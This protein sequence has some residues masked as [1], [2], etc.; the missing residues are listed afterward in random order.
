LSVQATLDAEAAGT[1]VAPRHRHVRY[2][3]HQITQPK[4]AMNMSPRPATLFAAACLLAAAPTLT[5]AQSIPA[6]TSVPAPTTGTAHLIEWDLTSLPDQLDGNPGAMVVDSRGEDQNR[7]WFIT[8]IGDPAG[9]PGTAPQ[10]V[11]RFDPARSLYS[12]VARWSSW[13]LR[14]DLIAGGIKK[15]KPSH[16]R[17][18]VFA[19]TATF[20]QK[21]DTQRCTAGSGS[22]CDRTVFSYPD[23]LVPEQNP[24]VSVSDIAVDDRNKVF[25]TGISP[26]FLAGY[27]QMLN[28]AAMPT[29][30]TS[31]CDPNT[32]VCKQ[33]ITATRWEVALGEGICVGTGPSLVCNAGI[34]V[35]PSKQNLVYFTEPGSNNIVELNI[36]NSNPTLPNNPNIRRWDVTLLDSSI[37]QPR[38]LKIDRWGRVWVN[39]G[40]GHL[41]SLDPSTSKMTKHLLPDNVSNDLFGIAPDDD[42]IGYTAPG[43]NKVGMLFPKFTP[44]YVPFTKDAVPPKPFEV[45]VETEQS[46][47]FDGTAQADAK[48]VA[49]KTSQCDGTC[50][51]AL[52]DMV[53]YTTNPTAGPSMSPLGITPVKSKAQGTFFYTVGLTAGTS[54]DAA[55]GATVFDPATPSV[56]RR[57]GFVRLP[58]KE[59][60]K[61]GRDD[62]DTDD[63]YDRNRNAKW[64]NSEPGDEDADGVPDQ[65]DTSTGRENTSIFDPASLP[66]QQSVAYPLTASAGTLA[67]IASVE[68]EPT[69]QIAVDIYNAL[70]VLSATSGPMVGTAV[71]TLPLPGAGNYTA[72][73]RNLGFTSVTS[74]PTFVVRDPL[75]QQ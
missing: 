68:A 71:C 46:P 5:F 13:E 12:S 15:I 26:T 70:G 55:T 10:R 36:S 57:I 4:G 75:V 59:K 72:R 3:E 19:R 67:L 62:D 32:G 8:R 73:V 42:V 58:N 60:I 23:Q 47:R 14:A 37:N 21:I 44:R 20:I 39:T 7:L 74:T 34:D 38:T 18:F 33:T 66:G 16:D 17:Q 22:T 54:T 51:E 53:M 40:S 43:M 49:S 50:I 48:I 64:H 27:V 56:A 35:H 63:G 25:T 30:S 45:I 6:G 24:F 28:A 31:L 29:R 1:F 61:N 2:V 69:A 9:V 65:Y 41:V 11:Y 52:I